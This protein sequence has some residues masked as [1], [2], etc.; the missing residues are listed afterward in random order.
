MAHFLEAD[1]QPWV[2]LLAAA[3][4]AS[5]HTAAQHEAAW[6]HL[7][8]LAPLGDTISTVLRAS[9][10]PLRQQLPLTPPELQP[11]V[12]SSHVVAGAL[13]LDFAEAAACCDVM[14]AVEQ[15]HVLSLELLPERG[16]K[17]K[18]AEEAVLLQ[19]RAAVASLP[20]LQSLSVRVSDYAHGDGLA[21]L[22]PA[23]SRLSQLESLTWS[24]NFTYHLS[25]DVVSAAEGTALAASHRAD[26]ARPRQQQA[27]QCW[28][29]G[30]RSWAEQPRAARAFDL[31]RQRGG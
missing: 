26:D 16:E 3:L 23:L 21:L 8:E 31:E 1:L 28:R 17:W 20:A 10:L 19:V 30:A 13:T 18:A 2:P 15:V 4:L 7:D 12:I 9:R 25:A 11:A 14:H 24:H 27:W 29:R 6:W 5:S 22:L